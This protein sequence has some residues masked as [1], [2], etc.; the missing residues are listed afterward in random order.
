MS[1]KIYPGNITT[2][3]VFVGIETTISDDCKLKVLTP[4][5]IEV[6]WNATRDVE[7]PTYISYTTQSTD[8]NVSGDYIIHSQIN[9]NLGEATTLTVLEQFTTV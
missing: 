5:G 6:V 8:L 9:N 7:D 2:L 4:E 3:K 1:Y